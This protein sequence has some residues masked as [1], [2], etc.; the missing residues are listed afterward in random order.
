MLE[1]S[2]SLVG[3]SVGEKIPRGSGR[4]V[5]PRRRRKIGAPPSLP[6]WWRTEG[7]GD[8]GCGSLCAGSACLPRGG[9]EPATGGTGVRDRPED[10]GEDA[11][12]LGAAGLPAQQAAGAPQAGQ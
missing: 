11:A 2:R 7:L 6:S 12:V 8:E 4:V 1:R 3:E 9:D 5:R 10:G